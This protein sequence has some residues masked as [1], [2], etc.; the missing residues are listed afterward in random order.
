MHFLHESAGQDRVVGGA[1]S[2]GWPLAPAALDAL[3][4]AAL[5]EDVGGGDLTGDVL[6]PPELR[7]RG[8]LV[9]KAAGVAA[10][11]GFFE[12]VFALLDPAL[13]ARRRTADGERVAPG[14][15]LLE[16]EGS[17]RALLR[18]ER[19]A[20]N[21]V[22]HLSG[23]ATT[24][25]RFV[26]RAAGRAEI[27]DTRKTLPGLRRLEKYAVRCGGGRNHRFGLFDEA[28][29]KNNHVDLLG[30]PPGDLVRRLRAAHGES[31]RITAEA[32]DRA[33]ALQALDGGADVVLLD[34]MS[35]AELRALCPLLRAEAAR[36]GRRVLLEASGGVDLENVAEIAAAG[37]DRVSVGALT[38]SAA[39]LDMAFSTEVLPEAGA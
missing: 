27:L 20:L 24:T 5:D 18:G 34:N 17:A 11:L 25:A 37:V 15:V 12:R 8:R 32:R 39:A 3:L 1:A 33:E 19:T 21:L 28:M 30:R 36:R 29:L 35:G 31:V 23:V 14:D 2:D 13:C 9:A 38:H 10:G 26:E 22:Q 4:R 16:L 7:A 6:V